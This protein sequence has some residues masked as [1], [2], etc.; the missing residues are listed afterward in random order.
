MGKFEKELNLI[1]TCVY[2]DYYDCR[3]FGQNNLVFSP[4]LGV[5]YVAKNFMKKLCSEGM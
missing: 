1:D 2:S 4:I 3:F 5:I